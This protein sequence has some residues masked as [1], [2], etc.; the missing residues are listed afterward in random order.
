MLSRHREEE[1]V[2]GTRGAV[3]G[4]HLLFTRPTSSSPGVA[5]ESIRAGDMLAVA[6]EL[7]REI[8]RASCR[9]RVSK[10]V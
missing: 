2:E 9:E 7:E 5:L 10:Q 4:A 6:V 1:V 3:D 8:G